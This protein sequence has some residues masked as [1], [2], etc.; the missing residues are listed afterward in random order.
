MGGIAFIAGAIL[1][2]IVMILHPTAHD[3]SIP[4]ELASG[5]RLAVI[6][7]AIAIA[8]APVS[9]LGAL[10]LTRCVD[11][12]RRLG[13]SALVVYGF[14]LVAMM[15]AA[16]ASGFVS[17]SLMNQ[18]AAGTS[19]TREMLELVIDYNAYIN[20][21][22]AKIYVVAASIAIAFWSAS[23]GGRRVFASGIGIYGVLLGTATIL[24][25]VSG[26]LKLDV[27]GMGLVMFSQS[28][29]FILVGVALLR[30]TET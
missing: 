12:P 15:V 27:H 18:A 2:V 3:L 22:F 11:A 29:W 19:T 26:H 7:H 14:G 1:G 5:A 28:I 30:W 4:G 9:F 13:L 17:P 21:A 23:N 24:M 6:V 20:Q 10:A 25:L 8:S 16:S